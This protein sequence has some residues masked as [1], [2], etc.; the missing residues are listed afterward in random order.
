M[1]DLF[2]SRFVM[3][4]TET[5]G[6]SRR[7]CVLEIAGVVVHPDGELGDTFESFVR[8]ADGFD[9]EEARKAEAVHG[10]TLD[11]VRG[12][13]T[14]HMVSGAFRGFLATAGVRYVTAYNV[15]FDR[16]MV[17]RMGLRLEWAPCAMERV[18]AH[19][20][21]A[22]PYPG[23]SLERAATALNIPE[24]GAAHRALADARRAARVLIEVRRR[25][26]ARSAAA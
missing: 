14:A 7:A 17:E 22:G 6:L 11:M 25:E 8:P 26:L 5:T 4:D 24:E 21:D 20:R 15:K 1:A 19:L 12:A 16:E 13:P 2:R 9:P 23:G 10:I 18:K 3:L